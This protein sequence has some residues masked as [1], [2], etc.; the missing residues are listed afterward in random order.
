MRKFPWKTA[1]A[2]TAAL[3]VT[4]I[5]F[6]A[7]LSPGAGPAQP[8]GQMQSMPQHGGTTRQPGH[9]GRMHGQTMN[10]PAGG[11]G[12][13]AINGQR[14]G[15]QG[16]AG[17]PTSPGQEAF[18]TIQEIVRMLEGDPSTDWSK[19]DIAALREHLI[20]MNEVTLRAKASERVRDN[21]VEIA[22]TGE[23]RTLEAVKRMVPA[24]VAE[25]RALGWNA[26]TE[27]MPGGVTLTVRA[28]D[29][30]DL[31]RLK[32]LGFIGIM[33]HGAHHQLHHLMT[34]KGEMPVH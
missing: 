29:A 18:G 13:R 27:D 1:L 31:A 10:G 9:V 6:A 23:G 24:H 5:A 33:V 7:Q 32:A 34:A 14:F 26:V 15:P 17:V 12:P 20:D 11:I 21:T 30:G 22:V 3:A 8:F 25:L 16:A 2:G 4:G 28:K 19:V